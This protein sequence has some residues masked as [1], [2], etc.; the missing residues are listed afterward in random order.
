MRLLIGK[1]ID[2]IGRNLLTTGA[3]R[4]WWR[5]AFVPTLIVLNTLFFM[6][7]TLPFAQTSPHSS[8]GLSSSVAVS[9]SLGLLS[10]GLV[11]RRRMEADSSSQSMS[12]AFSVLVVAAGTAGTIVA[13]FLLVGVAVLA[14]QLMR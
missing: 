11:Y 3:E 14:L 10:V 5:A 4:V 13:G 7:W 9:A 12:L 6:T 8:L 1:R 2:E